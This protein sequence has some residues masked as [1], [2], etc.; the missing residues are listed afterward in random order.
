M[1]TLGGI[2]LLGGLLGFFYC[3]SQLEGVEPLPEGMDVMESV[4]HPTGRYEV[5]R[6]AAL[7]VAGIGVLL[8]LYP[9]GR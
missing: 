9:K 2:L 1:R 8:A 4:R 5:G 3:T 7:C 6:W